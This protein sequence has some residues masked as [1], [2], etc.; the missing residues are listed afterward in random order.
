MG[1]TIGVLSK[2]IPNKDRLSATILNNE[3]IGYSLDASAEIEYVVVRQDPVTKEETQ[4][5][6]ANITMVR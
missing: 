4:Q 2:P 3:R 1:H 5:V 6:L